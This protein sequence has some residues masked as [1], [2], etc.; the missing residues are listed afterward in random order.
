M[1]IALITDGIWPY[2][3]GGMQKHSY[4]LCKY[5]ARNK[6]HVDL[7][8]FNQSA[9][10]IGKLEFFTDQEKEFIHPRVI[11]FPASRLR[12]PGHYIY[13]SWRYSKRVFQALK[14]ELAGYDLIYTKGFTG[15]YLIDQKTSGKITCGPIGVKFHGYEMFQPPPDWKIRIQHML[16]LRWPVRRLSRHADLVFSYGGKITDIVRSIGVASSRIVELPSGVEADLLVPQIRATGHDLR[17]LFLGRYERRKGIEELNTALRS[18]IASNKLTAEFHFIGPIPAERRLV[19]DKIVYHGEVRG[20]EGLQ[21]LIAKCDVLVCP[22]WSEGMPNVILEAMANGL[23]VIATDVGATNV[24]VSDQTGWL[25]L[26]PDPILIEK[27]I[28]EAIGMDTTTLDEKKRRALQTIQQRFT[29]ELLVP[30][31]IQILTSNSN[32]S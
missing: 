1:R 17:F 30:R 20:K 24:L 6:V 29:W 8:H 15:W 26:G 9:F 14:N 28:L 31:L 11:S 3:L 18:L 4:Y 13:D 2:V 10:N 5:L 7:V 22:S 27:T 32:R 25:L 21:A 12:F 19:H 23:A 16:L